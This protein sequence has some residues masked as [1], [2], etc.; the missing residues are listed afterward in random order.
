VQTTI[1][2]ENALAAF[3]PCAAHY[4]NLSR[5]YAAISFSKLVE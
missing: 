4:L 1:L 5:T 3:V 2:K